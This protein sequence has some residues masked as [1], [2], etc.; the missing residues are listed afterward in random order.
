M[1]GAGW[2]A[3][4]LP[5]TLLLATLL[6]GVPCRVPWHLTCRLLS[7][8]RHRAHRGALSPGLEI[9][10]SRIA[11]PVPAGSCA[12]CAS[13]PAGPSQHPGA[14]ASR[15]VLTLISLS[16]CVRPLLTL[17]PLP[18][19]PEP[20]VSSLSLSGHTEQAATA[21]QGV[22][23]LQHLAVAV[24]VLPCAPAPLPPP[25]T[26]A[27]SSGPDLTCQRAPGLPSQAPSLEPHCC[28][29]ASPSPLRERFPRGRSD[30]N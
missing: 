21:R 23:A 24:A 22:C 6:L 29:F 19:H 27:T 1:S 7:P 17:N 16:V 25:T 10:N 14:C 15:L 20:S 2:A 8:C 18:A 3:T 11:T 30:G 13:E 9:I 26:A 28:N 4:P 5:A 12:G